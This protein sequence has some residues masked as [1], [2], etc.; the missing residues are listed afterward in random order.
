LA[1]AF[2]AVMAV[3]VPVA[4]ANRVAVNDAGVTSATPPPGPSQSVRHRPHRGLTGA[5]Q[6]HVANRLNAQELSRVTRAYPAYGPAGPAYP[7]PGY[8][9]PWGYPPRPWYPPPPYYAP[10]PGWYPP[11]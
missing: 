8:A 11:P 1:A 5:S 10:G 2:A 6:D 9:S 7:P 3:T 4:A